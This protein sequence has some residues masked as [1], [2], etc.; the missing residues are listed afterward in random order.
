MFPPR[1]A[2]CLAYYPTVANAPEQIAAL[3]RAHAR[4][5]AV[6]RGTPRTGQATRVRE[7]PSPLLAA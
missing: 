4:A 6:R 3:G 7:Q 5:V 1:P 2:V